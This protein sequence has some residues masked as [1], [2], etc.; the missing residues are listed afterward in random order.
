ML[1]K[2]N[3]VGKTKPIDRLANRK[4]RSN[5]KRY[6]GSKTTIIDFIPVV[7]K[8]DS[9]ESKSVNAQIIKKE[10]NSNNHTGSKTTILDF[11]PELKEHIS[12]EMT[13]SNK[14]VVRGKCSRKKYSGSKTINKKRTSKICNGHYCKGKEL[15]ITDFNLNQTKGIPYHQCVKCMKHSRKI[16]HRKRKNKKNDYPSHRICPACKKDVPIERFN[17]KSGSEREPRCG[18]CSYAMKDHGKRRKMR[19]RWLNERGGREF[20]KRYCELYKPRR[21][22]RNKERRKNDINY[23]ITMNARCRIY[24]ILNQNGLSTDRK[25]ELLGTDIAM[26]TEWLEYQ[27]CDGMT[28]DNYGTYWHIDHV[29]PCASFKFASIDD[30]CIFECFNWKNTR[31][32][33][34]ADNISKGD[35]I[36]PIA[37]QTQ[38]FMVELFKLDYELDDD[39]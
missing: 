36:D 31:P 32:M 17:L 25:I 35:K 4:K 27:F 5:S 23:R 24:D 18:K 11:F 21:N 12:E 20:L 33:I 3:T 28:W 14:K 30:P 38:E 10:S 1:T 15:P 37:I 6:S 9:S 22:Q 7:K 16:A 19:I 34:A 29:R 13:S 2:K 39:A 26:Y 8:H